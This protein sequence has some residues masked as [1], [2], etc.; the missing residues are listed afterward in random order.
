MNIYKLQ[1]LSTSTYLK[2]QINYEKI[3]YTNM[4][5]NKYLINES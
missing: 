1:H 5:L 3:Y 4:K 2:L